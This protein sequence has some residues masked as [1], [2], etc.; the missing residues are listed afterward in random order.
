MFLWLLR[1]L[2]KRRP[3]VSR[4]EAIFSLSLLYSRRDFFSIRQ[5]STF[6]LLSVLAI[7]FFFLAVVKRFIFR[8]VEQEKKDDLREISIFV[9]H[10]FSRDEKVRLH[11]DQPSGEFIIV[12]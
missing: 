2:V 1:P 6:F 4:T 12:A 11:L 8:R 9:A 5:F 10:F 7:R 3:H